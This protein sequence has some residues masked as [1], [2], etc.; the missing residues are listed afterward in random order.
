MK[1]VLLA[2]TILASVST[3]SANRAVDVKARNQKP[4]VQVDNQEV[5]TGKELS[6]ETVRSG[7]GAMSSAARNEAEKLLNQVAKG[8][9]DIVTKN[10]IVKTYLDAV[11][12]ITDADKQKSAFALVDLV[13]KFGKAGDKDSLE[14]V[15]K[16]MDLASRADVGALNSKWNDLVTELSWNIYV[17][18]DVKLAVLE[19]EKKEKFKEV[20]RC[21]KA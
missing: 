6:K 18:S 15:V 20:R 19:V 16:V 8:M 4:R 17:K 7:H 10:D 12:K 21:R 1:K 3:A 13:G 5:K 11:E 14:F 2:V 9:D